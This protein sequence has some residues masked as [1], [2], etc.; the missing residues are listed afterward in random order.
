MRN[1]VRSEADAFH[2]VVA[3]VA[4]LVAAVALGALVAPLVGVALLVAG[5]GGALFWE[6]RTKDPGRR[7]PLRAAG[8][9]GRFNRSEGRRRVL[10]VANRKLASD[11]LRGEILQR[12][13]AGDA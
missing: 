6:L 7:P 13:E 5:V 12:E 8:P 9:Y 10:V 1:P 11:A 4:V 3:I 2:I